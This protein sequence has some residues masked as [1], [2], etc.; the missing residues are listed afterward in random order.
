[1]SV[2]FTLAS[3][4]LSNMPE[5]VQ[6][7]SDTKADLVRSRD[8]NKSL[9]KAKSRDDLKK[10]MERA[11]A[12]AE[13]LQRKLEKLEASEGKEMIKPESGDN[14]AETSESTMPSTGDDGAS[15]NSGESFTEENG[16]ELDRSPDM[17]KAVVT[18]SQD[19]GV[20]GDLESPEDDGKDKDSRRRSTSQPKKKKSDAEKPSQRKAKP[21]ELGKSSHRKSKSSDMDK[22]SHKGSKG[23]SNELS[24][25]QHKGKSKTD[26]DKSSHKKSNSLDKSAHKKKKAEQKLSN[27]MDL[28]SSNMLMEE[29][30]YAWGDD[31]SESQREG[32]NDPGPKG[33]KS[34][35]G[36]LSKSQ[37]KENLKQIWTSLHIRNQTAWIS[38][39][40]KKR[41]QKR[42]KATAWTSPLAAFLWRKMSI[43]GV[44][45]TIR[46]LRKMM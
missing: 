2:L 21:D 11:S 24:K 13:K 36:E 40:I 9:K 32:M 31:N 10:R 35:S 41:R 22:S 26:M 16:K 4:S 5:M 43:A 38:Q 46:N 42:K 3:S 37:H 27:S 8:K 1:M 29:N 34:K 39:A 12:K 20:T 7:E 15:T 6:N 33:S 30:E 25:S 14:L 23:K 18:E 44:M 19:A 17:P 45:T 28:S